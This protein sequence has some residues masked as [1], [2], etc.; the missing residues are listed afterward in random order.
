MKNI[1]FLIA[2]P[3]YLTIGTC[4]LTLILSNSSFGQCVDQGNTWNKSWKSC[5]V[6]NS[7]NASRA[8]SHWLLFEFEEPQNIDSTHIWNANRTGESDM[9][10]KTAI[11]DYSTD[12][13]SWIELGTFNFPQG[14]EQSNYEGFTGPN[15]GGIWVK[16][17]L[18]TVIETYGNGPCASLAEIQFQVNPDACYGELDACGICNGPGETAWY[19]DED[20]DGLGSPNIVTLA[21]TQPN[22]YVANAE[23]YCDN[24]LIG[25]KE[26][27]L[28]FMENGCRGCHGANR[29]GGLD[30][31]SYVSTIQGGNTCGTDILTGTTL[32]EIIMVD[33]YSGCGQALGSPSMNARTGGKIDSTELAAIQNWIN[34]GAPEDCHCG[35]GATDLD[36]DGICDFVDSCPDLD[37]NLIGTSCDDG[38]ACTDND[39]WTADCKCEGTPKQDTDNDGVCD[40]NDLAPNNPC[41]AD[42][43]VDG[44]EPEGWMNNP[45]NDCD[46]DG[47]TVIQG[48]L[49]DN[50]ACINDQGSLSTASCNCGS[51]VVIQGGSF[52]SAVGI[53]NAQRADGL[54]DSSFTNGIGGNN[55]SL[56]META[57]L[58][59]GERVCITTRFS[60]PDG[61]I[62]I[63]ANGELFTFLNTNPG[64][65][66]RIC[67]EVRTPGVQ[68]LL[69]KDGGSGNIQVDG[70]D[71][72][73]CACTD[74]SANGDPD[75]SA[76]AKAYSNLTGWQQLTNGTFWV[77]EGDS[78]VLGL[79]SD[80]SNTFTWT[81]PHVVDM[82]AGDLIIGRAG[83]EDEGLY[84][85]TYTNANGCTVRKD[86]KIYV[87]AAPSISYSLKHPACTDPNS[88]IITF[89]FDNSPNRSS[90]EFSISGESGPYREVFDNLGTFSMTD[91][92]SGSYD[93]WARWE[94]NHISIHLGEVELRDCFGVEVSALL[95]GPMQAG[96]MST[97]LAGYL[98]GPDPYLGLD[99]ASNIPANVVDWV[100]VQVRDSANN[101]VIL[102]QR[103]AFLTSQGKVVSAEGDPKLQMRDN[104]PDHAYVA[105]LHRNHLG[106]MTAQPVDLSQPLDFGDP[107]TPVFGL[108][109][110]KLIN[111]RALLYA[112]DANADGS[113]N[114]VD[115]N[116]F[117]QMQNGQPFQYEAG[118]GDM[119]MDGSVDVIDANEYW[120]INNG[121][122]SQ[123]PN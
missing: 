117:W 104:I 59:V 35:P 98:A 25:W 57:Y 78:L 87:E 26:I 103:A 86:I 27:D 5:T 54:P 19:K 28:I 74:F 13:S 89:N 96:S 92:V 84:A 69:I 101:K 37:N 11:I 122:A 33:G 93:L 43:I 41:T 123:I 22:G 85:A 60:D 36:G 46:T 107:N 66:Q 49:N 90:I 97:S 72:N 38:L 70:L 34:A 82:P 94:S 55:D 6:S 47:I 112:G 81:G 48:D 53:N 71:Y 119:N 121:K 62:R 120:R 61:R 77:C 39:I 2:R 63:E 100:L 88:G 114:A 31:T 1:Y 113:I 51:G 18:I 111:G 7:P 42:G 52:I 44:Q 40:I 17:I 105:L 99:S 79:D 50:D 116:R 15:F 73:Y 58:G 108:N 95:E 75:P 29:A 115:K 91:L 3:I 24:G 65:D 102:A 30:L 64:N 10:V 9:G 56:I 20:G 83:S 68:R 12:D 67:Y 4:L 16:K 8:N 109:P 32:A 14:S 45:T 21:C 23:D 80:I 118:G 76:V 106:V 110:R